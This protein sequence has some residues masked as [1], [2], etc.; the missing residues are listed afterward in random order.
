MTDPINPGM[1]DFA[2]NDRRKQGALRLKE[3]E[4]CENK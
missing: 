1:A 2:Y 3:G 4:T